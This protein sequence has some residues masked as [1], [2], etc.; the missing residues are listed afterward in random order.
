[1]HL[2]KKTLLTTQLFTTRAFDEKVFVA[3]P[4][5]QDSGRDVFNDADSIY[6]KSLELTLTGGRDGALGVMTFDVRRN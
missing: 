5:S 2:D 3:R 4:Y 6:D 1:M